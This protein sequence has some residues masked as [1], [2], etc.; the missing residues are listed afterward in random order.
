MNKM[1]KQVIHL[2][3]NV[4]QNIIMSYQLTVDILEIFSIDIHKLRE[5]KVAWHVQITC[6]LCKSSKLM[7]D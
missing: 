6:L 4:S 7:R 3:M 2:K 5:Y 1:R